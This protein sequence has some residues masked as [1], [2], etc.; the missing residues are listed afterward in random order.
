VEAQAYALLSTWGYAKTDTTAAVTFTDADIASFSAQAQVAL[1]YPT[2]PATSW[3]NGATYPTGRVSDTGVKKWLLSR[4]ITFD[5][6]GEA[7]TDI[8]FFINCSASLETDMGGDNQAYAWVRLSQSQLYIKEPNPEG[9]ALQICPAPTPAKSLNQYVLPGGGHPGVTEVRAT[10]SY[11]GSDSAQLAS[12]RQNAT[13]QWRRPD[14]APGLPS[15]ALVLTPLPYA[16]NGLETGSANDISPF[17]QRS[18]LAACRAL[19]GLNTHRP[20]LWLP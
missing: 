19:S 17:L 14:V 15:S 9:L 7:F 4:D 12:Y 20:R 6:Q 13:W 5:A 1:P 3:G 16:G 8:K 2:P 10:L 11:I 18:I